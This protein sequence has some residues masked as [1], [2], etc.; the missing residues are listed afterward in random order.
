MP[1]VNKVENRPFG[2]G[3]QG[4]LTILYY[5]SGSDNGVVST[6]YFVSQYKK[7]PI[8]IATISNYL[9]IDSKFYDDNYQFSLQ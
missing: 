5:F 1:S 7:A 9:Y 4:G 3:I 2:G 6:P 8:P